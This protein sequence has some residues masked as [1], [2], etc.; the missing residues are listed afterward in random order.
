[1][2][3]EKTKKDELIEKLQEDLLTLQARCFVYTN[4]ELCSYCMI[5]CR[6]ADVERKHKK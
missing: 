4:G 5:N 3:D 1:M 2:T 6:V